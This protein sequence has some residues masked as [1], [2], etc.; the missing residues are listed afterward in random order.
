MFT[1]KW[2]FLSQEHFPSEFHFLCQLLGRSGN[3]CC[4]TLSE[5]G[6]I[7]DNSFHTALK[8]GT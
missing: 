8:I 5:Y 3:T 7:A 4:L 2:F 6:Q 1:G